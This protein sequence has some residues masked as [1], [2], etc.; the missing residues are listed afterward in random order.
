MLCGVGAG[1]G[2]V[3]PESLASLVRAD[4]GR[5]SWSRQLRIL[6]GKLAPTGREHLGRFWEAQ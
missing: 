3:R 6:W 4:Y 2:R 1:R 5:V